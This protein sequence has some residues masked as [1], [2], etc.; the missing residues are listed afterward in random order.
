MIEVVPYGDAFAVDWDDF[1]SRSSNGT[2][3][4]TRRF[5]GYHGERFRDCSAALF[6]DGVLVGIL[7]AAIAVEASDVVVSHPGATFGGIVHHGW[8][9][10][11]RMIEAIEA[12]KLHFAVLG[13]TTLRY[14]TVPYIYFSCPA[15][16]DGYALFRVGARR[17]RCDLSSCIDL[18]ERRPPSSRR[19]RALRKANANVRVVHGMDMLPEFHAVLVDNLASRHGAAPVHE[20]NELEELSRRF[21]TEI[22]LAVAFSR[23]QVVA[24]VLFF[25]TPRVIHAQYIASTAEGF[26]FSALDAIFDE[27]ITAS[28][29]QGVRFFDFGISNEDEGRILNEG[30]YRF[31]T[32]FGGGGVI[33]EQFEIDLTAR[34]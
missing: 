13:F 27:A 20:L 9:T 29:D 3:L 22:S 24:G 19:R 4:H 16:D 10:G 2:F 7:P 8:L 23:D 26:E 33:L 25:R 5:L 14:K 31:K 1:C 11:Q 34:A 17:V 15:D 12:V 18:Q 21:P 28:V 6:H 32:E 30:L